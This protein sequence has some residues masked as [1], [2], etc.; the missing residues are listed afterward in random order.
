MRRKSV[1]LLAAFI[2]ALGMAIPL[3][4][5]TPPSVPNQ[6]STEFVGNANQD[7]LLAVFEGTVPA[8]R[9]PGFQKG[10]LSYDYTNQRM[11]L[12]FLALDGT[13]QQTVID[14]FSKQSRFIIDNV[15]NTCQT[16]AI[17]PGFSWPQLFGWLANS[18][19]LPPRHS[20]NFLLLNGGAAGGPVAL[21][22][23]EYR[24]PHGSEPVLSGLTVADNSSR[25]PIFVYLWFD[26]PDRLIEVDFNHFVTSVDSAGF[27]PPASCVI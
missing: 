19:L 21:D 24:A 27:T 8:D 16:V 10:K 20:G 1:C 5:Q 14:L 22:T 2:V 13:P 25:T 4:A 11:R 3:H 12:D 23:W 15:N 26:H 9:N 7:A 18:K 6:F 17:T